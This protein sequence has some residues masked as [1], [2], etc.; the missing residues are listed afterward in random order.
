MAN[1]TYEKVHIN[2]LHPDVEN[3]RFDPVE[4]EQEAILTMVNQIPTKIYNM[5]KSILDN[6]GIDPSILPN[7]IPYKK[8]SKEYIVMEGN[9][10]ICSL[11]IIKDISIIDKSP[12]YQKLKKLMS[13]YDLKKIPDEY[14]CTLYENI[15]DTY[16]WTYLRHA[17]ELAG[18][19]LV[20]W[21]SLAVDRF[22]IGT[23]QS[24]PNISYYIINYINGNTD[25]QI[26]NSR[27][28]TTL[29]RIVDSSAGKMYYDVDVINEEL[30]F[31]KD[32]NS[33]IERLCLL[34]DNLDN[35]NITSRNTNTVAEIQNWINRLDKEYK[36]NN[37]NVEISSPIIATQQTAVAQ[38]T[39][40]MQPAAA[41]PP[42]TVI[43]PTAAIPPKS[44]MPAG[45]INPPVVL[46]T[47]S[48]VG[49][50]KTKKLFEDL[51]IGNNCSSG[52]INLGNELVKL[53][54]NASGGNYVTY[55][56]ATAM[57][58]RAYIE[59]A[60]KYYL[61]KN[62]HWESLCASK[63]NPNGDPALGEIL[64]YCRNNRKKLFV[65]KTQLRLFG[66]LFDKDST[67]KDFLDLNI[68][69]PNIVTVSSIELTIFS[70]LGLTSFLNYLIQ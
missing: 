58:L 39:I 51:Y 69:H 17:G 45:T 65:D 21:D 68:H 43:S 63:K 48:T 52:I 55:P 29:K 11:K 24:K 70:N 6:G 35:K 66:I 44:V 64:S 19:G 49:K 9:R 53:S 16:F 37:S 34:I 36:L 50:V 10:R 13:K 40:E 33:T 15:Q 12:E 56:I 8:G 46:P 57:L 41:V 1:Y 38:Q 42:A 59:Q 2:N 54:K 67:I 7:I 14:Y 47:S 3:F 61:N 25:Y 28:A 22:K 32:K 60:F 18:E 26:K 27:F 31:K 4:N 23:N 62:E 20:K 5:I 30:V